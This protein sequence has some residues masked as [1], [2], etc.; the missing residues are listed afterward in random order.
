MQ[1]LEYKRTTKTGKYIHFL[2]SE[3]DHDLVMSRKWSYDKDG[4]KKYC[5]VYSS[6][7]EAKERLAQEM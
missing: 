3:C 1:T 2:Y 6:L 5:G 7:E 4:L